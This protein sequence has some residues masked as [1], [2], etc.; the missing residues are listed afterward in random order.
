MLRILFTG[1]VFGAGYKF[2]TE[3]LYPWLKEQCEEMKQRAEAAKDVEPVVA[4][5]DDK[6]ETTE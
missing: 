5:E 1:L 3:H 2:G 6:Y 4:D